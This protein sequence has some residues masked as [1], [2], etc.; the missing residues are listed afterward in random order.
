MGDCRGRRAEGEDRSV[1]HVWVAGGG[2][3]LEDSSVIV[4]GKVI[5][6]H[7][8]VRQLNIMFVC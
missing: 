7:Y 2:G 4:L 8:L 3:C 5:I 1:C 6:A